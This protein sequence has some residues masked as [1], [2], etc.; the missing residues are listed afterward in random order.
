MYKFFHKL[1]IKL[2]QCTVGNKNPPDKLMLCLADI[3]R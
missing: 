1:E 2:K 3:E